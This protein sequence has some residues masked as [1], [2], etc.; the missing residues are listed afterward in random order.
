MTSLVA[1]QAPLPCALGVECR[2][3]PHTAGGYLQRRFYLVHLSRTTD[4]Y[5]LMVGTGGRPSESTGGEIR[6]R[7]QDVA[8]TRTVTL[9]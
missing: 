8:H 1:L 6:A 2:V 3:G 5:G 4:P 7:Q 9:S